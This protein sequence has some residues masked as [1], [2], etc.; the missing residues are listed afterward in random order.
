MKRSRW[1][2]ALSAFALVAGF[3]NLASAQKPFL[4]RCADGTE[5][6]ATFN[7][8]KSAR[9]VIGGRTIVLPI[10]MSGSGSRY[11]NDRMT[12][13]IKGNSATLT[14]GAVSTECR[15]TSP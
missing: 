1:T 14:R 6:T 4:Y 9:L 10:A 11:A 15:T 7:G 5:L 2:F 12:F 8:M 3:P 13:W